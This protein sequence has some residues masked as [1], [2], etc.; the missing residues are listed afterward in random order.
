MQT[1]APDGAELQ[2]TILLMKLEG[3]REKAGP[4]N[5]IC[6]VTDA[7]IANG[8]PRLINYGLRAAH[9][10]DLFRNGCNHAREGRRQKYGRHR[11]V[12][13]ASPDA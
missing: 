13:N 11:S 2:S 10:H 3:D 6:R 7:A 9:G 1:D 12:A 4:V 5:G 8:T